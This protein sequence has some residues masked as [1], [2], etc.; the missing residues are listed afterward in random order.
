[1][2]NKNNMNTKTLDEFYDAGN[3]LLKQR[4]NKG[5]SAIIIITVGEKSIHAIKGK[6]EDVVYALYEKAMQDDVFFH[7]MKSTVEEIERQKSDEL[8]KSCLESKI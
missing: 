4:F 8:T 5:D 6:M 7:L 2:I 1:M 3:A